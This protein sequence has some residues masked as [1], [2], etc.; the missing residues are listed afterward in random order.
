MKKCFILIACVLT[1]CAHQIMPDQ[2]V[3]NMYAKGTLNGYGDGSCA[4]CHIKSFDRVKLTVD[5][6]LS[7]ADR[8]RGKRV[9]DACIVSIEDSLHLVNISAQRY[10][11]ATNEYNCEVI[12]EKEKAYLKAMGFEE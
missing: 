5:E 2:Y 6:E 12:F 7:S 9:I 3:A 10:I 11:P 8:Q 1:A 4:G